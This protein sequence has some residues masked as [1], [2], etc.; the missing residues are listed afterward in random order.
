MT[1][2]RP[3]AARPP[4]RR[5]AS[6]A[7]GARPDTPHAR[8]LLDRRP[9]GRLDRVGVRRP[10]R[11]HDP[12]HPQAHGPRGLDG[13]QGVVDRAEAGAGRDHDRKA[14]VHGQVAH[15]VAARERH[16]Q[17]ADALADQHVRSPGRAP[18]HAPRAA[19]GRS[20][21]AASSA[22]QCGDTAGPKV[23]GAT[24]FG[25]CPV[26]AAS[27]SWSGGHSPAGLVQ[28]GDHG[29]EGGHALAPGRQR[30]ADRGGHHGLA[31]V[32]VGAGDED[33]AHALGPGWV[34]PRR[35][36]GRR[37]GRSRARESPRWAARTGRGRRPGRPP[38]PPWPPRAA[39][40]W[41]ATP[42]R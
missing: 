8:Q 35:P 15:R 31:R 10:R 37:R 38:P 5:R 19:P 17:A 3:A 26:A 29:L 12:R 22:A 36:G 34:R 25:S 16:Q 7:V 1:T 11:H 40:T 41:C 32:G 13:Q 9:V 4:P 20:A 42:S 30:G 27:S 21:R 2:S 28:A 14:Q 24:S 18:A 23:Y 33:A 6:G 39:R